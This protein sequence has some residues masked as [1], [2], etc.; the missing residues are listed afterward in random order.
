[1]ACGT[2]EEGREEGEIAVILQAIAPSHPDMRECVGI[3]ALS[4]L[5]STNPSANDREHACYDGLGRGF[6]I[7][8][9]T[10]GL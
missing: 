1:M 3:R 5:Y 7:I 4:S 6:G 2:T 8:L 10:V 9:K